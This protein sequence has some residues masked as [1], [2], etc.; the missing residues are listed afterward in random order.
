MNS[1][2]GPPD[3]SQDEVAIAE[4]KRKADTTAKGNANQEHGS[5]SDGI[6]TSSRRVVK[7]AK[8]PDYTYY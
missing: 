6:T 4:V 7:S 1:V 8:L 5:L 2:S 3:D